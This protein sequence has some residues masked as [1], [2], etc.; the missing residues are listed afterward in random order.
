MYLASYYTPK[1]ANE[2]S[3]EELGLSLERASTTKNAFTVVGGVFNLPGWNWLT[4]T[5]KQD[6]TN[7]TNYYKFGDILDDNGLEINE[8]Y[9]RIKELAANG[10]SVEELW[11]LF[12]P[13]L[14]QSVNNHMPHQTAKQKDSFPWL[15]PNI[16]K[17]IHRR[18]RLYKKKKKSADPLR[19]FDC[20]EGVR[21]NVTGCKCQ[22]PCRNSL[23]QIEIFF[24]SLY[25]EVTEEVPSFTFENFLSN[26]GGS[27]GLWIG[28]SLISIGELVELGFF[29][30]KSM[31]RQ[32]KVIETQTTVNGEKATEPSKGSRNQF[33]YLG[34]DPIDEASTCTDK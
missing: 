19:K 34:M 18:D 6:F 8:T 32:K 13:K 30:L 15:T 3:L 17:L 23:M 21:E 5:L 25:E 1:T 33:V 9:Q 24:S 12:K 16:R 11:L 28:M 20:I 10:S 14:N 2:E 27:L 31:A 7:Q 29:L 4:R 26:I 22:N